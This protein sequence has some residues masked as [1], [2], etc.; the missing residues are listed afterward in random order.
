MTNH[1][2]SHYISWNTKVD[3]IF[4][5]TI[6]VDGW[7]EC[8]R[9]NDYIRFTNGEKVVHFARIKLLNGTMYLVQVPDGLNDAE[10]IFQGNSED[11]AR[12]N[13]L[14]VMME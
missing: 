3:H 9:G 12:N 13:A 11:I 6:G 14:S 10:T 1:Q 4:G 8:D 7:T 2:S 5:T